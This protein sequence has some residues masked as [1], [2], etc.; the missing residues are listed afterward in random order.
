MIFFQVTRIHLPLLLAFSYHE[1]ITFSETVLTPAF[2][3]NHNQS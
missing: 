1:I 2:V 3:A